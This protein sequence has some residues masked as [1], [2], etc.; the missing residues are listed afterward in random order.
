VSWF[1]RCLDCGTASRLRLRTRDLNR[2]LSERE[3]RYYECPSCGVIFLSP[4]P[5]DLS[6]FYPDDYY[7]ATPSVRE[8]AASA[9]VERYKLE[10]IRGRAEGGRLL[11][12]G[13]GLSPFAYLAKQNGFDVHA[14]EMDLR[15]CRFLEEVVGIPTTHSDDPATALRALDSFDVIAAWH[16]FEHLP[17]PWL[18]L[19][20]AAE[21]LAPQGVLAIA[22]PNPASLQLRLVGGKWA[23]VDAPR[24]LRL[25]PLR[26]FLDH[27]RA[28]GLEPVSITSDDRGSRFW[29]SFG[30]RQ[31]LVNLTSRRRVEALLVRAA[32]VATRIAAPFEQSGFRGST[33]SVLLRRPR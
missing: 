3:F 28:V 27:A 8:L 6:R 24:H 22:T 10:L 25:I 18:T 17:D 12:I 1:A 5:H 7:G 23:H 11:E 16:V 13:P 4:T 30:W 19:A 9:E 14:L 21:R 32:G 26:T 33:Y 2:R 29:N 15:C 31:S 20:S